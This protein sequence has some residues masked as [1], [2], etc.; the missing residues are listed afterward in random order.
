MTDDE[1]G[2]FRALADPTR[3]QILQDL[4]GGELAAGEIGARFPISGPS[5]SRHL[6]VLKAAALPFP[7][8]PM[9]RGGYGVA[10]ICLIRLGGLGPVGVLRPFGLTSEN[11]AH[12]VAVE[13]DGA[14][15]P[16][17]GVYVPR[18]DTSSR[19][20]ALAGGRL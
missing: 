5:V 13:W 7:F 15:G 3:R 2:V 4:R 20:A 11:V 6:S 18:R 8:R 12:R 17:S 9:V 16:S 14:D 10:G 1:A 19:L